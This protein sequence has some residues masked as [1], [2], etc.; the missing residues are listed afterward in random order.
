MT[1]TATVDARWELLTKMECIPVTLG[2]VAVNYPC[3]EWVA[4][5]C[6]GNRFGVDSCCD[7]DAHMMRY[8]SVVVAIF[9]FSRVLEINAATVSV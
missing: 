7:V 2:H 4:I 5:L 6:C 3:L 9:F 1:V 8:G